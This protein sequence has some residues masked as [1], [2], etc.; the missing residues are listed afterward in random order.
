MSN[1]INCQDQPAT[2][3]VSDNGDGSGNVHILRGSESVSYLDVRLKRKSEKQGGTT[4]N[5]IHVDAA[6]IE[7]LAKECRAKGKEH[8]AQWLYAEVADGQKQCNL[9]E[10]R[11]LEA[12][13]GHFDGVNA[14]DYVA[15]IRGNS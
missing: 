12:K 4:M 3:W 8:L 14:D 1:V 10:L 13:H 11:K 15:E 2:A 5:P 9:T 6:E 7:D